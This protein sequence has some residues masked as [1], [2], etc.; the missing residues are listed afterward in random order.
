[1]HLNIFPIRTVLREQL[2][3]TFP[4]KPVKYWQQ[5]NYRRL[6]LNHCRHYYTLYSVKPFAAGLDPA[7][8]LFY[9]STCHIRESDAKN[10]IILHTDGGFYGTPVETGSADFYANKGVSPQPGCPVIIGGGKS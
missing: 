2:F 10:V 8:P 9:P 5:V 1:M 4:W 3:I 6:C 7:F